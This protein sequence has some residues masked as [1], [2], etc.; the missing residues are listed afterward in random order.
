MNLKA[1]WRGRLERAQAAVEF[2]LIAPVVIVVMLVGIQFAIIGAASLGLG[3]VAYQG[4]RW[5]AINSSS[6]PAQVRTYMISVASPLIASSNGSYLTVSIPA[7]TMPC[8]FGGTV[9]VP[10]SFDIAHLVV[11]PNPFMGMIHFPTAL[12]NS[13]SAFCE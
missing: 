12:T 4:A 9:Q 1:K 7:G 2:A 6:T 13:E 5:A 8:T 10:V 3:D 11:L